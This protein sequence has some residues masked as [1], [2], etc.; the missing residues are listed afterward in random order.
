MTAR[1]VIGLTILIAIVAAALFFTGDR[2]E[3]REITA[4]TATSD[5]IGDLKSPICAVETLLACLVRMDGCNV[6]LRGRDAARCSE[7]PLS[8]GCD[9][10]DFDVLDEMGSETRY[11][12]GAVRPLTPVERSEK[13]FSKNPPPELVV[14]GERWKCPVSD[15]AKDESSS[16]LPVASPPDNVLSW[17]K[18]Q[19]RRLQT[20]A[21]EWGLLEEPYPWVWYDVGADYCWEPLRYWVGRKDGE[22]RVVKWT[23]YGYEDCPLDCG[24][25]EMHWPPYRKI[26]ACPP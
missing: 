22:W 3:I 4:T 26:A 17:L 20:V 5:C 9:D 21:W 1:T 19:G 23:T 8:S 24:C 18:A 2:S 10:V 13:A 11:R 6:A 16:A 14:E 25:P 12:I 15:T 7:N